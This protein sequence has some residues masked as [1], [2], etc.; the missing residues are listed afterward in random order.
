MFLPIMMFGCA[1][2]PRRG[3]TVARFGPAPPLT[4]KPAPRFRWLDALDRPY[5]EAFRK[6][7]LYSDANVRIRFRRRAPV[8][9]GTLRARKL[10]PNFAYQMKVV[11][12]PPFL[13]GDTGDVPSNVRIGSVGRWWKPGEQGGNA[14]DVKDGEKDKMEG[15]FVFG[16]FVTDGKGRA[17]VSFRADSSYHVLWKTSQR[18][19]SKDD[20]RPTKHAMVVRPASYGY[21]RSYFLGELE[22]YAEHQSDR[23]ANGRVHLPP[24]DYRCFFLLTEE[25]FHTQDEK[26][27]GDW[28]AA[29]AK[30]ISF[31]ITPPEKPPAAAVKPGVAFPDV[32]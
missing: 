23:P 16:C 27:G 6:E 10:K 1:A 31:T 5:G 11:G 25:S 4:C 18:K 13:W 2:M 29:L 14:S 21:D 22:I 26:N 7:F 8:F 9:E 24:G 30:R 12:M 32:K 19:P 15:Y 3:E 28:A 20:S 17:D